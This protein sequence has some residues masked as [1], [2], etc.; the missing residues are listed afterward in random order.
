MPNISFT[1]EKTRSDAAELGCMAKMMRA[2][3]AHVGK[4]GQLDR[5]HLRSDSVY[6][7]TSA[8]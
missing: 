6:S 4:R 1:S 2:A 7:P 3:I 5:H 8:R